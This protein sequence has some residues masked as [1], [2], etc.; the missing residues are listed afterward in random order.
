MKA[1]AIRQPWASMIL[2][3]E[4][5]I[6]TRTW[7]TNYR[8]PILIVASKAFASGFPKDKNLPQGQAL[9][10][11]EI[12]DCI[13]MTKEH[14]KAACCPLYDRANSWMLENIRPIKPFP[15]KGQLGLFEVPFT[16]IVSSSLQD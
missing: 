16:K 13:P 1:L 14:E 4:K 7:K 8:G 3:G 5:T 12:V 11:A 15:V 10:I 9:C 6:E 2:S